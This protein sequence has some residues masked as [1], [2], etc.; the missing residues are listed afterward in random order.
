MRNFARPALRLCKAQRRLISS[1]RTLPQLSTP[2]DVEYCRQLVLKNDYNNYLVS[3]FSPLHA[4]E[5][6]WGIRALNIEL[7]KIHEHTQN[8]AATQ[9]R[10]AYWRNAVQSL[11]TSDPVQ[12]PVT[13]VLFDAIQRSHISKTW[14]RRLLAERER[15]A[16]AGFASTRDVEKYG[17]RAFACLIHVH[18]EALGVRDMHADNAA[19]AIGVASAVAG[20][21][22]ALPAAV[23]AGRCDLP[24]ELL[25]KHGVDVDALARDPGPTP[26]LREAVYEF[27]TL[28]YTKL[29]GVA[30]LYVPNAPRPAFPA[31]LAAIPVKEWLERLEKAN[32]DVFDRR[33]Q[34]RSLR[35]LWQLWKFNRKGTWLESSNYRR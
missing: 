5:A 33:L 32:F 2:H 7:L 12:T 13:R 26:Q 27:A 19:R 25:G 31:L 3:L 1:N 9:L 18:L 34:Q 4:R 6:S 8:T 20:F 17:E 35:V 21:L 30:E 28:G 23:P 15:A 14:I 16:D 10:F 24:R 11:F 29:C 22:R